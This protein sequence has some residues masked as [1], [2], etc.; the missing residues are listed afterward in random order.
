MIVLVTSGDRASSNDTYIHP[1]R[2]C[3]EVIGGTP[4]LICRDKAWLFDFDVIVRL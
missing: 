4:A 2:R 3:L 1:P